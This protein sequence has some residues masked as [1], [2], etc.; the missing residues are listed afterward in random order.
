MDHHPVVNVVDE[1]A[2]DA[3]QNFDLIPRGVPGVRKG[4]GHAVVRDGDGGMAP[5]DGLL[6][7]G[8]GVRQSVHVA[9]PGM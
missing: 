6:D 2:L 9:H 8:L 3:V 7:H 5:A 1:I 4:L